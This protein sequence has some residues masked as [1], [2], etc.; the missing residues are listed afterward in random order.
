[1]SGIALI[2]RNAAVGNLENGISPD[3]HVTYQQIEDT[4]FCTRS[5]PRAGRS[6]GIS[7]AQC[8]AAKRFDVEQPADGCRLFWFDHKGPA[9]WQL[10]ALLS[11]QVGKAA[12][13]QLVSPR[14]A[15]RDRTSIL[16][17]DQSGA[18]TSRCRQSSNTTPIRPHLIRR[19]PTSSA[20][21][22]PARSTCLRRRM[23]LDGQKAAALEKLLTA[24]CD[25]RKPAATGA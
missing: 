13:P 7:I 4:W 15:P 8:Q 22:S 16:P 5:L 19:A 20:G 17:V 25:R 10:C 3:G 12:N 11:L 2:P 18:R 9:P 14:P 21:Y 24:V 1:M 6:N 23:L